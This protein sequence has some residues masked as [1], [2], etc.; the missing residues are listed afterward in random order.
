M[1]GRSLNLKIKKIMALAPRTSVVYCRLRWLHTYTKSKMINLK[2]Q[3]SKRQILRI[4][5]VWDKD[6]NFYVGPQAPF[7]NKNASEE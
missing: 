2:V 5:I 7:T 3:K 6:S 4:V 1:V